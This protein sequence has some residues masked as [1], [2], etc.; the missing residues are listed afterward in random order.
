LTGGGKERVLERPL[1][2]MWRCVDFDLREALVARGA[3]GADKRRKL[4]LTPGFVNH[5]Q[6]ARDE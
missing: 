6:T 3:W 2:V 1:V 4:V 5:R